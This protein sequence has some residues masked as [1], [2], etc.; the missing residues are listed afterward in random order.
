[1]TPALRASIA[2]RMTDEWIAILVRLLQDEFFYLYVVVPAWA[3]K[4][5]L[6]GGIWS[7]WVARQIDATL[8]LVKYGVVLD[9]DL[10]PAIKIAHL[11]ANTPHL[12][13]WAVR[14]R[15]RADMRH[16]RRRSVRLSRMRVRVAG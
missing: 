9:G 12:G 14:V 13:T 5:D 3:T 1:M 10:Y 6:R 4:F 8:G 11:R 15:A 7:A 2:D 16:A